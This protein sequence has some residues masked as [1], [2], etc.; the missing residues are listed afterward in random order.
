MFTMMNEARLGW[1]ACR[2]WPSPE[3]RL[4]G[5]GG[6]CQGPPA[7]PRSVTGVENSRPARPIRMIVHPDVRRMLLDTKVLHR[8]R[9]WA[10]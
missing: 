9:A 6:L 5:L 8:R 4:S 7:G 3:V 10:F 2:A 1:S